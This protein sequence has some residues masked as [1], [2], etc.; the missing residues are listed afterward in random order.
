MTTARE[1]PFQ[2]GGKTH[3]GRLVAHE[4]APRPTVIVFHAWD[5]RSEG[6]DRMAERVADLGWNTFSADLYGQGVR[7]ET[8]EACQALMTPLLNDRGHL[9][10]LLLGTVTTVQGLAETDAARVAAIGFCFGGLC[11]LDLA[12]ANAPLKAVASFHGL[13]TPSGLAAK[14]PITPKVA[15]FHGWDDPMAPPE[16]VVAF[17]AE[18][19]ALGADWQIHG[20]G[21]TLHGFMMEGANNPALGVAYN[22]AS[23]RRAFASLTSLLEESLG[24]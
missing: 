24:G 2:L 7:G 1:I 18:F 11:V 12:R 10:D 6:V 17:A 13:F 14:G 19:T 4:G 23:A 5:G 21:G 3:Q 8:V 15:A 20:Y 22:P 9:R 16:S